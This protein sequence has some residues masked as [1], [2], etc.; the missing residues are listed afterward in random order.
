MRQRRRK[1]RNATPDIRA[2]RTLPSCTWPTSRPVH[3]LRSDP[4]PLSVRRWD[5]TAARRFSADDCDKSQGLPGAGPAAPG[6]APAL[7]EL[8]VRRRGP[9]TR[10]THRHRRYPEPEKTCHT[11]Q[12]RG[13]PTRKGCRVPRIPRSGGRMQFHAPEEPPCCAPARRKV[14]SAV[15]RERRVW[16]SRCPQPP[17]PHPGS[18]ALV[19]AVAV[20]AGRWRTRRHELRAAPATNGRWN[21]L[22]QHGE[23]G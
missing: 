15:V 14:G 22:P 8:R 12:V 1:G 13:C 7:Q 6:S 5:T 16:S 23:E 18:R 4:R 3:R 20:R 19:C 10:L 17:Q 2:A 11:L 9:M 21:L